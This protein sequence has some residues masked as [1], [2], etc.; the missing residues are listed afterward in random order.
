MRGIVVTAMTLGTVRFTSAGLADAAANPG[1]FQALNGAVAAHALAYGAPVL[2]TIALLL[3]VGAVGKSAQIPLYV[4]LPDAMEG[5][6]PVSA[7]IPAAT[8][9]TTAVYIVIRMNPI[10]QLPP[11]A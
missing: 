4:W 5:P 8:I 3:F 1:I 9:V 10:Y 2:T 6:T 7:L 11:F